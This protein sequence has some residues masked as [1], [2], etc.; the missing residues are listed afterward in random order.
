MYLS[1]AA[2]SAC[3][4]DSTSAPKR[5]D[6]GH[7]RLHRL[8]ERRAGGCAERLLE[9]AASPRRPRRGTPA[10]RRAA[11]RRSSARARAR[12]PRRPRSP[13]APPSAGAATSCSAARRG[14]PPPAVSSATSQS[15]DDRGGVAHARRARAPAR[16][17]RRARARCGRRPRRTRRGRRGRPARLGREHGGDR[18]GL[19]R[20]AASAAAA[21]PPA[22]SA[23]PTTAIVEY[24]GVSAGGE[25]RATLFAPLGPTYDRYAALLSFG[26]D[27]R[28]RR[29]LV[30]RIDAGPGD[31]VLD[32]ATGT[33]GRGA[34]AL[35]QKGC[36]V[37][38]LDQSAGMLATARASGV[39]GRVELV[40]GSA[41][42]LPFADGEFEALTFTYLLRYVDDPAVTLRELA[43]V[44]APG[45]DDR[46]A[47]V[48]RSRA[49]SGGPPG[50]CT[51]ASACPSRGASSRPAGT[52]SAAS[53][54][55]SIRDFHSRLPLPALL[56]A[57]ARG[58]D[59]GRP[60]APASPRRRS[61][62]WGRRAA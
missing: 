30:S 36:T 15:A 51:S 60:R 13:A 39:D 27:P 20:R 61:R 29:F 22:R 52:R 24:G 7:R 5:L 48:R 42:A 44:V 45:G 40:E 46:H 12:P 11:A 17:R 43:R 28:W 33:G 10:R 31:R 47:R 8:R 58:R 38:G 53:S 50:S 2:R 4:R 34:R 1:A 55:R 54:A 49:G 9:L 62:V 19:A 14:R 59:R 16:R 23:R 57:V 37:V 56:G 21:P 3:R 35:R 26:Q 18:L 25:Q 6:R 32:V 41:D